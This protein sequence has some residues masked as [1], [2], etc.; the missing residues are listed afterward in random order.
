[1]TV[2]IET[3][4]GETAFQERIIDVAHTFGWA[5][6]H[7]RPARTKHGWRTAVAADGKGW[8]DLVLVHPES[9]VLFREVKDNAGTLTAD[10]VTWGDRFGA[11]GADWAV[12]RPLDWARIVATLTFGRG[13]LQL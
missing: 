4:I 13:S 11:A 3:K 9:P 5:V 10:Q 6:A 1:M 7:F 8:P 12:W 2:A